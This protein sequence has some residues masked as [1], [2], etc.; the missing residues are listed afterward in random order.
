LDT[1]QIIIIVIASIIVLDGFNLITGLSKNLAK[2]TLKMRTSL[3]STYREPLTRDYNK[4]VKIMGIDGVIGGI[5]TILLMANIIY[6]NNSKTVS[7]GISFGITLLI[8]VLLLLETIIVKHKLK[9][10][11]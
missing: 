5:L 4:T 7:L 3:S 6:M 8:S 2:F 10:P 1:I 9:K 11:R